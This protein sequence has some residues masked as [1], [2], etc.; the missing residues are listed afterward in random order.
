MADPDNSTTLLF[1]RARGLTD[2]A[3]LREFA[4]GLRRDVTGGRP[5][6][7]LITD[8]RE[9]QRLNSEFLGH[10]YPTDVL[11]FPSG[12]GAGSLGDMAISVDRAREQAADFGHG[13][14]DEIRILMLHGALHLMGMDHENDRGRMKRT[15]TAWRKRLGLPAGLIE[16]VTR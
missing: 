12:D 16:R 5:F 9:L 3:A 7:C 2:R 6:V 13:L 14:S 1:R 11:S 10:D 8:D 15:E 4:E